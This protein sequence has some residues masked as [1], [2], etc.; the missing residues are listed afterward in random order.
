MGHE[1]AT[2]GKVSPWHA[3]SRRRILRRRRGVLQHSR[4]GCSGVALRAARSL[5][6]ERVEARQPPVLAEV[7]YGGH[8]G[9]G[10][11]GEE[12]YDVRTRLRASGVELKH[13]QVRQRHDPQAASG[14]DDLLGRCKSALDNRRKPA[15]IVHDQDETESASH[16]DNTAERILSVWLSKI[17]LEARRPQRVGGLSQRGA[18]D[19]TPRI[20]QPSPA[21]L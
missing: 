19:A 3:S 13:N 2:L 4:L 20:S 14:T 21:L 11:A 17:N 18:T 6:N 7:A 16:V 9:V 15:T 1:A 10:V 8:V 5:F 12:F